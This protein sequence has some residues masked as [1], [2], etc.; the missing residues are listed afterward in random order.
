MIYSPQDTVINPTK[1]E[2]TIKKFS[3]ARTQTVVYNDAIDPGQHVLFGFGSNE[4]QIDQ[5]SQIM[6]DFLEVQK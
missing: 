4:Q 6:Y 3:K 1:A 5:A 2:Q